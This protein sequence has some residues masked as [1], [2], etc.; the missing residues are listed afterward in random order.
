MDYVKLAA[1]INKAVEERMAA[2]AAHIRLGT[3]N[4]VSGKTASVLIDGSSAPAQITK[5]CTCSAGDRVVI[6]RQATQFYAI[7]KVGG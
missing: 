4:S 1:V 5:A 2:S 6:L 7:A 3:V